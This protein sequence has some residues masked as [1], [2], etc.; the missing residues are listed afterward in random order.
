MT[1]LRIA[2]YM[3]ECAHVRV[4]AGAMRPGFAALERAGAR[5]PGALPIGQAKPAV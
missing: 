4:L 2:R 5:A 3:G 1:R